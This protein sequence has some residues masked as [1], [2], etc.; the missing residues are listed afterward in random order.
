MSRFY[1]L[2]F[3]FSIFSLGNS[4]AFAFQQAAELVKDKIIRKG[5]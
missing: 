3:E 1:V 4:I 5:A 2:R